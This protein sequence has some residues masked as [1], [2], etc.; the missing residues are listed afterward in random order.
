MHP[1]GQLPAYEW[2]LGDV[3]PP[4]H[5][6]AAHRVFVLERERTG[7]SDY[8]FLERVFQKLLMNFTWWVNREDPAGNNVFQGGF[9][10]LD[11]IGAFNRSED[12]P[13]GWTLQQSD[14]TS[15]MAVYSLGMMSIAWE[16]AEHDPAYEDIASKF[17]E[18]FLYIAHAINE[19]PDDRFGL[20]DEQDGFYYDHLAAA[21]GRRFALKVR[22][23]VGLLPLLAVRVLE[24]HL[25]ARLPNFKRRLEWFVENRP[26]LRRNVA[27]METEG[28]EGR[29]LLAILDAGRLRRILQVALDE[30]EF[31]SPHGI[32]SLSKCHQEHPFDEQFGAQ[33]LRVDYE[34]GESRSGLFGGNSNWRGPV[35]F[36]LNFLIVRAL[37]TFADYYGDEFT[38]EF[39][40][41]SGREMTLEQVAAALSAR[42]VGIFR[43]DPSGYRPADGPNAKLQTDPHF[44]DLLLFNEYFH[45][46]DGRGLGA[47]HQTGWTGLVAALARP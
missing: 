5:A 16:L 27:C 41:G 46:D 7:T 10:G 20:W 12:L 2:S 37:G 26:E 13:A 1:N 17:F 39:P 44:R 18:H 28:M 14:A 43:R 42:L 15:W 19:S 40:S 8:L 11:N 38:L 30:R 45:G 35:W 47:S 4:V 21:D 22:S 6:W 36:P 25:L 32:R 9:L 3:N 33:R 29:R 23:L 31:L 34:P 24:P